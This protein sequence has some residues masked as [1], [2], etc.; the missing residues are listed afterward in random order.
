MEHRMRLH[1]NEKLFRQAIQSTAQ[2]RGILDI[3]VEK[4]YWVTYA[5]KTVFDSDC[6]SYSVF[7]GGTALSKCYQIIERF[8]EDI[9]LV[10][11]R[12]E[13]ESGNSLTR[14]IKSITDAVSQVLPQVEKKEL[15]SKSGR[16]RKTA[17]EYPK[18]VKG[19]YGQ[20]RDFALSA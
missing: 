2:Q 5:I 15:T 3:Y 20:V 13:G 14:K 7:K 11:L 8:S 17:H 16:L 18:S 10:V 9:D 1:E 6:G 12:E 4:D 19:G